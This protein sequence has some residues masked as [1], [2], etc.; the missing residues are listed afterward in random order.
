MNYNSIIAGAAYVRIALNDAALEKGLKEAQKRVRGFAKTWEILK[1]KMGLGSSNAFVD[2]TNVIQPMISILDKFKKLNDQMLAL[3][4]ISGASKNEIVEFEK[5]IRQLGANTAFTAEEV[6]KGAVELS[7]MG[8]STGELKAGLKPVLDLV[9][10]TGQETFRLGEISA[11]AA[12][13]LRIFGLK[14]KDFADV[15]DVMAYA[16]NA[17]NADIDDLGEALKIAGP[18]ARTVNEDLRDTAAALMLLSNA[19]VKGSL[20]GTSLRK[21]YQSLAAQSGK[22][23]GLSAE[24]IE[25]G[26]RGIEQFS[27]LGV[28]IIDAQSGNLRKVADII[29]DLSNAVKSFKTGEKINFATDVFDL[30]GSLGALTLLNDPNMLTGFREQLNTTAGYAAQKA[31]EMEEGIGGAIRKLRASFSELQLAVGNIISIAITPLIQASTRWLQ[32]AASWVE[33][34]KLLVTSFSAI[35]ASGLVIGTTMR[36]VALAMQFLQNSLTP[37]LM[38]AMSFEKIV[39]SLSGVSTAVTAATGAQ[40]AYLAVL[41][42]LSTVQLFAAASSTKHALSMLQ[43]SFAQLLAVRST[44]ALKLATMGLVVEKI[45]AIALSI[46]NAIVAKKEA[47][48]QVFSGKTI[49]TLIFAMRSWLVA[50]AAEIVVGGKATVASGARTAAYILEAVAVKGLALATGLLSLAFTALMAH[51][52]MAFFIAVAAGA[53]LAYAWFVKESK[54]AVSVAQGMAKLTKADARYA[55]QR[56]SAVTDTARN[57]DLYVTRIKQLAEI[58]EGRKLVQSELNELQKLQEKLALLNIDLKINVDVETGVVSVD[59]NLAENVK[60]AIVPAVV[61]DLER[62]EAVLKDTIKRNNNALS[63]VENANNAEQTRN[64]IEQQ[65]NADIKRLKEVQG[66]LAAIRSGDVDAVYDREDQVRQRTEQYE[67]RRIA[68]AKELAEAKERITE[69]DEANIRKSRSA[70]QNEIADI[71]KTREEYKKNINLLIEQERA[72]MRINQRLGKTDAV[73]ASE[74]EIQALTQRLEA[75]GI[76]FD[77]QEKDAARKREERLKEYSE[78][79]AN[80]QKEDAE[81]KLEKKQKAEIDAAKDSGDVTSIREKISEFLNSYKQ[82]LSG[83]WEKYKSLYDRAR[84]EDS[85]WGDEISDQEGSQLQEVMEEINK[86]REKISNYESQLEAVQ[87]RVRSTSLGS[88]SFDALKGMFGNDSAAERT[89]NATEEQVRLQKKTQGYMKS[90]VEQLDLSYS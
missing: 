4:A 33:Q 29:V 14:G 84:A 61:K 78:F 35:I 24:E 79:E 70:Y 82:E 13:A 34:N 50:K 27:A 56:T 51:P 36:L 64:N 25:N 5:Y 21:I 85:E 39:L 63:Q 23:E 76:A 47:L 88:F 30:R 55:K 68:A 72:K 38:V 22:T 11:Y 37:V 17:S 40:K 80:V 31:K 9:R 1:S 58:S 77:A 57:A 46:K 53:A 49:K 19:G 7:R 83:L 66:R 18:S 12:S 32:A 41:G 86:R 6:A 71:R 81:K 26:I 89:A 10:A 44:R 20:A 43:V 90:M 3:K 16:A 45:K 74:K 59:K 65:I 75:A 48:A 60:K 87:D 28:S 2:F 67:Q 8:F 62:E 52:V 54:A 42:R 15:C 69:I 73:A